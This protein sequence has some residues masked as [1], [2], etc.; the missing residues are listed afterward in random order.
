M[1]MAAWLAPLLLA[2][3]CSSITTPLPPSGRIGSVMSPRQ[4]G[5]AI[6]ELN[7]KRDAA[8]RDAETNLETGSVPSP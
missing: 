6:E 7:Q 4:T 2:G 1:L 3:G 8:L 5:E